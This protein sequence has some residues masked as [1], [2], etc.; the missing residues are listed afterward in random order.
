M[1]GDFVDK[2]GDALD[3]TSDLGQIS[4]IGVIATAGDRRD[5]DMIEL[6]AGR[7]AA[8]RRGHRPGGHQPCAA[9]NRGEVAGLIAEGVR[10]G[11]GRRARGA[12]RSRSCWTSSTPPG[13]RCPAPTRATWWWSASTS[14]R[15]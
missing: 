14:T 15:R 8:L 6:G 9:G 11:D 1:L 7:G 2:T 5:E 12:S 10:D 13:T 3:T 4:R